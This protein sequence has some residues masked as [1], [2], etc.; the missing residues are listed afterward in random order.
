MALM[1]SIFMIMSLIISIGLMRSN[2]NCNSNIVIIL[3][4]VLST[5]QGMIFI[6]KNNKN[7]IVIL[8]IVFCS[9]L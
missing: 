1:L 3:D 9:T 7:C 4:M 5:I 8:C 6:Y 2:N